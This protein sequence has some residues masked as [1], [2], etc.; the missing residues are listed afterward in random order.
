[1]LAAIHITARANAVWGPRIFEPT[2]AQQVTGPDAA[3]LADETRQ[4]YEQQRRSTHT[5]DGRPLGRAYVTIEGF[6]WLGY[7]SDLADL[8]LVTAGP[9]DSD[10]TVRAVTRV[11]LEWR[12]GDWRVVGPP[13]GNWAASAAPI[14]S[15][16][17][18]TRFPQGG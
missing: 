15:A 11:L 6:R 14:E 9:G 18:Y 13:N 16:D 5:P 7:T 17:G 3:A 2:I 12:D 4:A 8:D 1:M 10:A